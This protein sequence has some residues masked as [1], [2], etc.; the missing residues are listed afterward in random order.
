VP[1][2]AIEE[3]DRLAFENLLVETRE[4]VALVAPR[5]EGR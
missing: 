3:G 1:G 5:F 2:R 4:G